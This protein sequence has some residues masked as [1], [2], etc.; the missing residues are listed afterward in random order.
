MAFTYLKATSLSRNPLTAGVFK[1]VCTTNQLISKISWLQTVG[2]S[3]DFVR[4]GT[5]ASAAFVSRSSSSITESSSLFDQLAAPLRIIDADVDVDN[6]AMNMTNPNGDPRARQLVQKL[7]ATGQL[8]QQKMITGSYA[9]GFTCG[10]AT[11]TPGLAVDAAVPS[12][13]QDSD[14]QGPGELRYTHT[15]TF[16]A[17]RAPGDIEFGENVAIALDGSATL[18]SSN[19]SKSVYVTID[20]SDATADGT[21]SIRFTSSSNEPDGLAKLVNASQTT[22]ATGGSGD[23]LSFDKLDE[24]LLE[25]VKVNT[26]RVF[27]MNSKLLRKYMALARAAQTNEQMAVTL[28]GPS[29]QP[30]DI[31]TPAYC[32]VPI[33]QVDDIPSTETKGVSTLSSVY[34]VSL[35]PYEGFHGV[36][37]AGGDMQNLNLDPYAA[38]IGG[39]KL[40]DIGQ[41][42][43]KNASRTRVEWMGAF[44][45]GSPLAA[46]RA[47]QLITA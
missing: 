17:Y 29:G 35:T 30:E 47:S 27:L 32:G 12:G 7:K 9:T 25:K 5:L 20:V 16:W 41:L 4:E 6:F 38:R 44:G 39:F 13:G 46:A 15:G 31:L 45:L 42:E 26:D 34:L 40:Y 33:L 11:V 43:G 28:I 37:Q 14:L 21:C 22:L 24:L 8:I 18:Y 19:A 10:N 3:Y 2:S 23:A 36:V 1:A